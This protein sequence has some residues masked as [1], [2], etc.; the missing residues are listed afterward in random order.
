DKTFEGHESGASVLAFSR[1]GRMLASG[2]YDTTILLWDVAAAMARRARPRALDERA[3]AAACADLTS[4]DAKKAYRAIS[5]L[6]TAPDRAVRLL[7]EHLKPAAQPNGNKIQSLIE[8]LGNEAFAERDK[9][10][11]QLEQLGDLAE[12]A[13]R[14]LVASSPSAEARRRANDLLNR[15]DAPVADVEWL[16][17]SR[18][19]EVLE[20]IPGDEATK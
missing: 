11:R 7:G 16:R 3:V 19:I 1:D 8:Q 6:V 2:S 15:L 4:P 10:S 18:A 9:A 14:N 12:T 20:Q 5:V 17:Q 13:L